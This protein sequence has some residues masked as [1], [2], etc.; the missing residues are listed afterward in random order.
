MQ[1]VLAVYVALVEFQLRWRSFMPVQ[2]FVIGHEGIWN[3]RCKHSVFLRTKFNAKP[4]GRERG[5]QLE[6]T[7]PWGSVRWQRRCFTAF[8]PI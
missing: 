6:G 2:G 8:N 5:E 4:F 7:R 3:G 1:H